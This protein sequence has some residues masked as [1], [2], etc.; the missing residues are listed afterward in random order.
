MEEGLRPRGAG[1]RPLGRQ[2]MLV[3]S[4]DFRGNG[5]LTLM[6]LKLFRVLLPTQVI[7]MEPGLHLV[8]IHKSRTLLLQVC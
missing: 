6:T 5:Y 3:L 7:Q 2:E 8:L 4:K 1:Y